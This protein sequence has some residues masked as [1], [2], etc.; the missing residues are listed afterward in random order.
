MSKRSIGPD[1]RRGQAALRQGKYVMFNG[2][3]AK[4]LRQLKRALEG[5]SV[6]AHIGNDDEGKPCLYVGPDDDNGQLLEP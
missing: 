3:D 6:L 4:Y 5:P 2:N 1:V